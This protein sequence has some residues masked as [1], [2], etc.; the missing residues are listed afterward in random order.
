M[1]GGS[2]SGFGAIYRDRELIVSRRNDTGVTIELFRW[3]H[4]C[5]QAIWSGAMEAQSGP[6]RLPA[7]IEFQGWDGDDQQQFRAGPWGRAAIGVIAQHLMSC[8]GR[9]KYGKF[10]M[11][12]LSLP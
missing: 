2:A 3:L 12:R 9:E 11:A 6:Q 10:A 5:G 1:E 8:F 4:R 7:F